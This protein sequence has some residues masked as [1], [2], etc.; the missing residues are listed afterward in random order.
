MN[1][2]KKHQKCILYLPF[3]FS[4]LNIFAMEPLKLATGN[5]YPPYS[6]ESL[7]EG[8]M[9]TSI[10][11]SIL[12]KLKIPYTIEF[13]PWARGY[14]MVKTGKYDATFPY[15]FTTERNNEVKYSK[16]SIIETSVYIFANIK[17]KNRTNLKEF[18]G[19]TFCTPTGYYI[20][21]AILNLLNKNEL[22]KL[23]KFNEKSCLDAVMSKEADFMVAS[24]TQI[25][26]Y[27]KKNA[28]IFKFIT[29]IKTPINTI[30]LFIIYSKNTDDSLIKKIDRESIKFL[31]TKEFQKIV[32]SY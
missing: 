24:E 9:Y 27:K 7:Q 26:E 29:K 21:D 28:N 10:V 15:A 30:K 17:F 14:D 11:K 22:K 5:D 31:K 6:D 19:T 8:G 1:P 32:N 25:N 4:L 18:K 12:N 13:L 3:L 20:E 23:K 16:V 2:L